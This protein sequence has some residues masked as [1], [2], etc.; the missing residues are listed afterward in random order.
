MKITPKQKSDFQKEI[1]SY[2]NKYKR[3]FPWRKTDDPYCIFVSEMMLQQ[4]Q[5]ERVIEKYK[6]FIDAFPSCEVLAK[7]TYADVLGVWK[8]LGYNRRAKWIHEC[9]KIIIRD[10]K[11]ILPDNAPALEALPG[12][13]KATARS[14]LAFAYN[15]DVLFIE[16]NIR[17]MYIHFFFSDNK[18]DIHDK[19]ILA[20][21]K[22][23]YDAGN[24]REWYSALMDYGVFLKK[25]YGNMNHRSIHYHK[26]SRFEGSD[27][28]MRGRLLD[29]LLRKKEVFIQDV[30]G[31]LGDDPKRVRKIIDDMI[32]EEL[33]KKDKNGILRL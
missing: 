25:K 11:G 16:T 24:A 20:V 13:G 8:G 23:T 21:M 9:A 18:Q 22:Q 2:Y 3:D 26:Q 27:R 33:F 32:G 15:K 12:I 10:H 28:Q 29:I 1:Y 6:E 7:S 31:I 4:T 30:I 17:T 14:M 5:T 19:E